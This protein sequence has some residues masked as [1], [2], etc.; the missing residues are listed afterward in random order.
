AL[1][2]DHLVFQDSI[3]IWV[4]FGSRNIFSSRNAGDLILSARIL[5]TYQSKQAVYSDSVLLT[6]S[7][8]KWQNEKAV[9]Q[10]TIP[11]TAVVPNGLI[12]L[13]LT[14]RLGDQRNSIDIAFTP[15]NLEKKYVVLEP[16]SGL[17][18][19]RHFLTSGESFILQTSFTSAEIA[20]PQYSADFPPA[21]P[22]MSLSEKKAAPTIP[23]IAT[24]SLKTNTPITLTSPG[25]YA[26][27]PAEGSAGILLVAGNEFPELTTA[28]ELI[29]PLI[30]I[31]TS[32]ERAS[33]YNAE[34]PKKAVDK[35]WLT[36]GGSE[37]F[38]RT[39]IREY[40]SRVT[41]ANKLFTSHKP[42]WM[43]DRGMIFTVMGRPSKVNRFA[44]REEWIY[45]VT[46]NRPTTEF[47]FLKR[48]NNLTN[49]HYELV[50]DPVYEP[51]WFSAAEQWRKGII[52]P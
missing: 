13:V 11:R 20:A 45:V 4:K 34:N 28:K 33:L 18:K 12:N 19:F 10:V 49:N 48:E 9:A 23:L 39:L 47:T 29:D 31:T 41:D 8:I 37:Q 44:D 15:A 51:I 52:D 46:D 26:L 24:H 5:Q 40:Y 7:G 30:Y 17:P 21:L 35:F 32:K 3:Q 38:T 2:A 36:I 22:P 43:S 27:E 1:A 14:D 25:L 50:R 6:S 42:G 16:A